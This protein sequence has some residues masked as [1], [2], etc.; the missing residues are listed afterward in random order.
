METYTCHVLGWNEKNI[1]TVTEVEY[2][3]PSWS[4][5]MAMANLDGHGENVLKWVTEDGLRLH[6][7][8]RRMSNTEFSE[9]D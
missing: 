6:M 2:E 1:Q 5:A 9:D 3:A 7:H 4:A 8:D